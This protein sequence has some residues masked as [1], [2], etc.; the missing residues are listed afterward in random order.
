MV[1]ETEA[2]VESTKAAKRQAKAAQDAASTE[3][4]N[5]MVG[6]KND[7]LPLNKDLKAVSKAH[8]AAHLMRT[9]ANLEATANVG[10]WVQRRRGVRLRFLLRSTVQLHLCNML[11][12]KKRASR[13]RPRVLVASAHRVFHRA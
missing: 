1:V 9:V 10:L 5:A 13:L 2:A 3:L 6:L 8:D 11:A 12:A 7:L 4:P